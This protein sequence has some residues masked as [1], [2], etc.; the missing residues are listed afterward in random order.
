MTPSHSNS[1]LDK[2]FCLTCLS[3]VGSLLQMK[4]E[5]TYD[6]MYDFLN[7]TCVE[8]HIQKEEVCSGAINTTMDTFL[9][10]LNNTTGLT[11]NRIC[12]IVLQDRGCSADDDSLEWTLDIDLGSKP[13]AVEVS[14]ENKNT[15]D[16]LTIVHISDIHYDPTYSPNGNAVCGEPLCCRKSQSKQGSSDPP[17][18]FWGDYRDC[19]IPW[20]TVSNTLQQIKET[21]K[22]IDYIYMTG[23]I[24]DHAFWE[25]NITT[26]IRVIKTFLSYLKK[27]FPNTPIY[28]VIGNHDTY[29]VNAFAPQHIT[30]E[31][32]STNWL[33]S[34]LAEEWS[35]WLPPETKETILRG[36]YYTVL[37]KPGFRI[38]TLNSNFCYI[39][40]W[41]LIYDSKDPA[42][43]LKWLAETLL[44]AE[45]NGEK[46]H[47]LSHIPTGYPSCLKT[48]SREFR[49]IVHRFDKTV[50]A[51]FNGHTHFDH[52][53]IYYT[54][55][56]PYRA[57]HIAYNGGS[58]TPF[59]NLNPNYKVYVA[60]SSSFD[61]LDSET[62][63][64]NLTEAN[65]NGNM[66]PNWFKS[67]SFKEAYGVESL[68]PTE[69]DKL[70]HKMATNSSLLEQ[71]YR[72]YVKHADTALQRGCDMNCLKDKLCEI[73][74]AQMGD[75]TQCDQLMQQSVVPK[76]TD[77]GDN[78][79]SQLIKQFLN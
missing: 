67:Y 61:V 38:V 74:V 64:F 72:Y 69:M 44:E 71:Y 15:S 2:A 40:N 18:G 60:D 75:Y 25:N 31:K 57:N 53:Y 4:E 77:D 68:T 5:K 58:M 63:I 35:V 52:F 19:D 50:T 70:I 10:I 59:S 73:S 9:Y 6:E 28:P 56:E 79:F 27:Q 1:L 49:K 13:T 8:L 55:D 14:N 16:A 47:I 39:L 26:S 17:A 24:V 20:H 12:G 46:V 33:Y 51:Q 65:L 21:H 42:G 23:D 78:M 37:V 7:K 48:W 30:D 43:Q 32:V 22:K 76:S 41:W 34:L 29:P 45:K 62:W 54:T 3:I 11:P 66:T 36:G